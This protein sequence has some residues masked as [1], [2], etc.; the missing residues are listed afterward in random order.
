MALGFWALAT[1][2]PDR[3]AL[4]APD[5]TELTAGELHARAGR[6][7]GESKQEPQ[8]AAAQGGKS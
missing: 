7:Q 6:P 2:E 5:G 1:E 8:T 4:V 3:V